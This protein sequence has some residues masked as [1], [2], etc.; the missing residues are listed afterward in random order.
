MRPLPH[1]DWKKT[2]FPPLPSSRSPH[3]AAARHLVSAAVRRYQRSGWRLES[4]Q[5]HP[6]AR[7]ARAGLKEE[8]RRGGAPSRSRAAL[9]WRWSR[10]L[11]GSEWGRKDGAWCSFFSSGSPRL[12]PKRHVCNRGFSD[13]LRFHIELRLESKK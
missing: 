13:V 1:R 4:G 11:L 3:L 6:A 8:E 7:R 9:V 2:P 5:R 10:G 12:V